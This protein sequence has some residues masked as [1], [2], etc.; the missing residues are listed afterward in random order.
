MRVID[1]A[2]VNCGVLPLQEALKLAEDRGRDLIEIAPT[3]R[4]PV[5][6]VMDF[7]RWQ[8]RKEKD[9]RKAQR[10]IK[11]SEIKGV[12]VRLG[13]SAHDIALKMNKAVAF[14]KE[15]HKIKL[16]LNLRGREKYLNPQFIKNRLSSIIN[17]IPAPT[18]I[19]EGPKK[20]PRGLTVILE[21]DKRKNAKDQQIARQTREN[22]EDRQNS[23][24]QTGEGSL[25]RE[26]P[27]REAVASEEVAGAEH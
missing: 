19:I 12:R 27:A 4:P 24:P 7:G 21:L 8:Y 17:N 25:Q 13:T 14:L 1:E 3:A 22:N 18:L 6:R 5:A 15:G 10:G 26:S 23:F 9:L 11:T 20:G 16:D 2:G